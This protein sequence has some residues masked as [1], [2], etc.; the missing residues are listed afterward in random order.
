VLVQRLASFSDQSQGGNPAGVV[1]TEQ[2]L[3]AVD[4]QQIA[5]EVGYSETAF[6]V[7]G[8]DGIWHVRYFSPEM[9][10]PFCGH[11]TIAL[12]AA[13]A[14]REGDKE[15]PLRINQ[16]SISVGGRRVGSQYAATLTSPSTHSKALSPALLAEILQLFEL[17]SDEL[18][19]RIP[20]AVAHAGA[21]H[22]VIVL[23]SRPL[24]AAM[25]Y[26][27]EVGQALMLREGWLT[28]ML[29]FAE[30]P[31]L[32][33]TR[34]AFASGGVYED[35]ASGAATAALAGYL[36]DIKWPHAGR[37]EVHQGDDMQQ[38]SRLF[39]DITAVAGAPIRVSGSVRFLP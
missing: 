26:D 38:P 28:V 4:M 31:Q 8:A 21:D 16:G 24:L 6:A 18:D 2:P 33:H 3:P 29:G 20:P 22:P 36:R 39:A 9:E 32:F 13:L 17:N 23:K 1:I 12:G 14:M 25:R 7:A 34:N 30:T 19:P 27:M 10:V 35:P 15:F 11:A 5:K 37:L